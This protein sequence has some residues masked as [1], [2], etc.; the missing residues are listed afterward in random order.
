MIVT[1]V[2]APGSGKEEVWY[3]L[4]PDH[5][6]AFTYVL[7]REENV[8][9]VFQMALGPLADWLAELYLVASRWIY[10]PSSVGT[11]THES[12][13]RTH[14]LIDSIAYITTKMGLLQEQNQA[15]QRHLMVLSVAMSA[16]EESYKSDLTVL[17]PGFE[18]D[19][20][21]FNVK[22]PETLRLVM[23]QFDIPFVEA[24]DVKDAVNIIGRARS[25][26]H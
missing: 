3:S 21:N 10:P 7:G 20:L 14:S 6:V 17:L 4:Q 26:A 9:P 8:H 16:L 24:Q 11:Y 5:R 19:G 18:E 25:G 13:L 23:E 12:F 22:L 15:L 1:L 2:G